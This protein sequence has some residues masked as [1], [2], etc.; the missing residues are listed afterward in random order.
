MGAVQ[1]FNDVPMEHFFNVAERSDLKDSA[2]CTT[3]RTRL[4]REILNLKNTEM[5]LNESG[6]RKFIGKTVR[7]KKIKNFMYKNYP[8]R[9][10][11]RIFKY[12]FKVSFL[13]TTVTFLSLIYNIGLKFLLPKQNQEKDC[14]D[15]NNQ[16][17]G[18]FTLMAASCFSNIFFG[19]G[20]QQEEISEE[21]RT[22]REYKALLKT[23][24]LDQER[25][26]NVKKDEILYNFLSDMMEPY[27]TVPRST[28]S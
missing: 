13:L 22:K 14:S 28:E 26:I 11:S 17:L 24:C 8:E 10:P 4:A 3:Y 18:T 6:V 19:A 27:D 20:M 23:T 25:K 15:F 5:P 1:Q 12:G 9:F 21:T 16:I 2:I 7:H